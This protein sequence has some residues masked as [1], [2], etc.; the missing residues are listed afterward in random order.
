[1]PACAQHCPSQATEGNDA[2]AIDA[3]PAVASAEDLSLP[4]G[5]AAGGGLSTALGGTAEP[6]A[7]AAEEPEPAP[8]AA[9]PAT[10]KAP[11]IDLLGGDDYMYA[12]GELALC[13]A[14]AR[15]Y[16]R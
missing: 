16:L 4:G 15:Q 13:K 7:T 9:P 12:N 8:A 2:D 3:A 10:S 14:I 5:A 1:M 6:A 11:D